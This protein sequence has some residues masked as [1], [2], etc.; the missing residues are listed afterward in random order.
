MNA[1]TYVELHRRISP[2]IDAE[3]SAVLEGLGPSADAVRTA[4][5][6][7]LRHQ[8]M[9]YPLSVLPPLVHAAETGA[10]GPAVAL[11]AVHVLWWTS[12]CYLDDLADGHRAHAPAG[13]GPDEALL[14]A[15]L[16]GQAL[17][18]RVVQSQPV[19]DAVRNALT[20]EIVTCWI[21]AVEG[22]LRDLRG[23]IAGASRDTVLAAYRGKSGAPFGMITAMA[24]ILSGAGAERIA[25]WREFGEVFGLLWQL[26]N[27]QEDLLSGRDE[28]LLNGTATYL[29]ACALEETPPGSRAG[30]AELAVAART[31]EG[32]RA[33][34]RATLL[35]P[36][37]L[38]RYEKDL[39]ALRDDA[40]RVLG[41]LGGAETYLPTLRHLI[42]QTARMRLP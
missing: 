6:G 3:I 42:D 12:A 19:P 1:L 10:P 5:A 36:V 25:R 31:S 15:V 21:D 9:K 4:M 17:S 27:D 37:V 20:G 2:D 41:E 16:G 39:T 18:I 28:D 34:L 38:R 24:A 30:T 11:S 33:R 26:F 8:R 29:L 23:D 14:A 13:L 22:Q 40:H 35:A 32:A 7:L